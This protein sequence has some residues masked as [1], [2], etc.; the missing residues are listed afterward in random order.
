MND[1][2]V[3]FY[4]GNVPWIDAAHYSSDGALRSIRHAAMPPLVAEM[5]A[6]VGLTVQAST[7]FHTRRRLGRHLHAEAATVGRAFLDGP[8][9]RCHLVV[10]GECR[11]LQLRLDDADLRRILEE[12]HDDP[13]GI[14]AI[15][16]LQGEIDN[17]L[18]RLLA[19]ALL[20][21]NEVREAEVRAVVARLLVVHGAR[22][23]RHRRR[24]LS[25]FRLRRVRDL[26][27]ADATVVT[28]GA[29]A[30][31]AGLSL[32]HFSREFRRETGQTPWDFVMHQRL[33][34]AARLLSDRARTMEEAA[35]AAGFSHAS[36]M[37]RVFR[38]S[39]GFAPSAIRDRLLP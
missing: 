32:Y 8:G 34:H 30:K 31:E 28:L 29:M 17:G 38:K 20:A 23:V 12:D 3:P 19:R 18:L 26:V 15:R 36:H 1:R 11:I 16:P 37:S 2:S 27:M 39:L 14:A 9:E 10:E 7:G 4:T 13:H 25:P 24:D 6:S 21:G 22:Q 33:W 35:V 5:G